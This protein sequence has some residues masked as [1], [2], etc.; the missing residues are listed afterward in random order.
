MNGD[1]QAQIKSFTM[2]FG[3]QHP[4]AHGVLRPEIHGEAF[5]LR[6]RIAVHGFSSFAFSSPGST[7]LMPS[8][9]DR[10]SKLRNSCLSFT[11]S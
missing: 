6:L 8:H 7:W 10:K 2:N 4:A 1:P 3:P 5:D 11:G 9:G